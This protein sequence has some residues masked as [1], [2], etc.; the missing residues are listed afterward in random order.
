MQTCDGLMDG[1]ITIIYHANA[2][3]KLGHGGAKGCGG[4]VIGWRE[5]FGWFSTTMIESLDTD[6]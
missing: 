6:W 1:W 3:S 5:L 4:S 2:R